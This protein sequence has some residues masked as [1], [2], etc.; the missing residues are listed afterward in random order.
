MNHYP[1]LFLLF[2]ELVFGFYLVFN[3]KRYK[4]ELEGT[5]HAFQTSP[6]W[7]IVLLGLFLI[8]MAI[9]LGVVEFHKMH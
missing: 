4:R 1:V 9:G 7:S 8:V 6:A 2:L 5:G 3:S